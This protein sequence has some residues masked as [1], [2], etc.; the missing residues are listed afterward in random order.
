MVLIFY[1]I[2]WITDCLFSDWRTR[3]AEETSRWLHIVCFTPCWST[4]LRYILDYHV[5]FYLWFILIFNPRGILFWAWIYW[6]QLSKCLCKFNLIC[7]ACFLE[8]LVLVHILHLE[9]VILT[10]CLSCGSESITL[11]LFI[12]FRY[13]L[14]RER[15]S[16]SSH[17]PGSLHFY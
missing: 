13:I 1:T 4:L 12:L 14:W 5:S 8:L 2:F 10:L 6:F 16:S 17:A 11:L 9:I 15:R 7:R 3:R